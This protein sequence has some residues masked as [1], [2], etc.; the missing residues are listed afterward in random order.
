MIESRLYRMVFCSCRFNHSLR[1][2]KVSLYLYFR[3][4][5]KKPLPKIIQAY[6][7]VTINYYKG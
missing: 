4:S 2:Q 6:I 5:D 7:Y 1:N 3:V